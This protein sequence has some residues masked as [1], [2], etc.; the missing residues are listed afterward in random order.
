M[1]LPRIPRRSGS[2]ETRTPRAPPAEAPPRHRYRR[3]VGFHRPYTWIRIVLRVVR[4]LLRLRRG[5]F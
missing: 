3:S 2:P 4:G 5:R 1:T